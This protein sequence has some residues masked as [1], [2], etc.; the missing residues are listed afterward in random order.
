MGEAV[1]FGPYIHGAASSGGGPGWLGG[2]CPASFG[3]DSDLEGVSVYLWSAFEVLYQATM[4]LYFETKKIM[5]LLNDMIRLFTFVLKWNIF[6]F[7]LFF[8]FF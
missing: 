7:I 3:V 6:Q 5:D 1:D 4:I 2:H 8:F